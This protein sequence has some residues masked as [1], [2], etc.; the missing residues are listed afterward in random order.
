ML[1]SDSAKRA[2]DSPAAIRSVEYEDEDEE[3]GE[4][5]KTRPTL[6]SSAESACQLSSLNKREASFTD[7]QWHLIGGGGGRQS[8][9]REEEVTVDWGEK[10][11]RKKRKRRKTKKRKRKRHVR[12]R[13]SEL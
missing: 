8:S 1:T 3:E 4:E 12:P 10:K 9:A 2:G 6:I 13:R 7:A 5:E 11:R